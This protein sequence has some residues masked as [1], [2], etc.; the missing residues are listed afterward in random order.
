MTVRVAIVGTGFGQSA[1][2]PGFKLV[3]Q[4]EL[5]AIC[6]ARLARAQAAAQ[7]AGISAAYDDYR[8]MLAEQRPDLVCVVTPTALHAP[9]TLAA[10]ES[11]AHVICE[12]P[13]ALDQR[14]AAAMLAAAEAAGVIHVLD[15]ELRFQPAR[16]RVKELLT[17]GY[18]GDLRS[19]VIR[20]VSG[21]RAN[22]ELPWDWW[23]DETAGGGALGANGSHQVDLLR[24][25][26][27]EITAVSG[28]LATCVPDRP[29]P[30]RPGARRAV[31]SDDQ[32][33]L[34]ARLAGG[35]LAHIFVSYI[36]VHGGGNQIE[37]HGSAGSLVIDHAERLW[38]RRLGRDAEDLTPPDPLANEPSIATNIWAR[39]CALL[40][41]EVTEA[42]AERRP[43]REAAT[44][45]DGLRTQQVLDAVRQSH[46]QQRW[47]HLEG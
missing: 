22:S 46:A 16:R 29:D 8:V 47:V 1:M 36:A 27:G 30:A 9:I 3:P 39:A 42:I 19:V 45:A 15:H 7:A 33:S 12:K 40:V 32:F 37:L 34:I 21:L 24:W 25:W 18:I 14:E 28:Q 5:V 44:F 6:S 41:R 10:I 20:S 38:G 11:G 26:C 31:T 35:A 17:S 23:Y 43:V 2:V 13:M 4:A